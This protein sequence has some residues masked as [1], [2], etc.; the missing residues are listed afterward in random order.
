ME[1]V[2]AYSMGA[3]PPD[4]NTP[5]PITFIG[6]NAVK[7]S[8]SKG[9][10]ERKNE[11]LVDPKTLVYVDSSAPMKLTTNNKIQRSAAYIGHPDAGKAGNILAYSFPLIGT[12]KIF[13]PKIYSKDPNNQAIEV[14]IAPSSFDE[15]LKNL[16]PAATAG[17]NIRLLPVKLVRYSLVEGLTDL[18]CKTKC[19]LK[20][21]VLQDNVFTNEVIVIQDLKSI[22]FSRDDIATFVLS[23]GYVQNK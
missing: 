13:E 17:S 2:V 12:K 19:S 16:P 15:F 6:L 21:H 1:P 23:I 14:V 20:R 22:T 10:L 5:T 18:P 11:N 9:T 3:Q 4:M 8:N 7:D